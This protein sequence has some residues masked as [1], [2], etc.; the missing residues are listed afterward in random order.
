MKRILLFIL[1]ITFSTFQ[2]YSQTDRK[3]KRNKESIQLNPSEAIESKC[4]T[5]ILR[6]ITFGSLKADP[7]R[8]ELKEISDT[9]KEVTLDYTFITLKSGTFWDP[10]DEP[11]KSAFLL[12]KLITKQDSI[13][14]KF[15]VDYLEFVSKCESYGHLA[16]DMI[17]KISFTESFYLENGEKFVEMYVELKPDA[18][19]KM[20][21]DRKNV[22]FVN[23]YFLKHNR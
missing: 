19:G 14:A 16:T 2:V 20:Q 6:S 13:N 8:D 10:R 4:K 22:H 9:I 5:D 21:I 17:D 7:R 12:L 23:E 15:R 1:I 3:N 18:S 11:P